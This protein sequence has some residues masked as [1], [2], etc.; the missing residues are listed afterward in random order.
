MVLFLVYICCC[1]GHTA[2]TEHYI[3]RDLYTYFQRAV[4][5]E[6]RRIQFK[7]NRRNKGL[8]LLEFYICISSREEILDCPSPAFINCGDN[9]MENI[10]YPNEKTLPP[11]YDFLSLICNILF[12]FCYF[13]FF[14]LQYLTSVFLLICSIYGGGHDEF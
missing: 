12:L 2:K 5:P 6:P 11:G 7:C 3:K 1:V 13:V 9:E 4:N 10:W 8:Q 14:F